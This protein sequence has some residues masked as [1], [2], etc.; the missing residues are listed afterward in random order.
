MTEMGALKERLKGCEILFLDFDGVLTDNRVMVSETGVESVVCDRSD[1]L[2]IRLLREC[3][4]IRVVIV[5]SEENGVVSARARKLKVDCIQNLADKL[6]VV[7]EEL[8]RS[9]VPASRAC[10]VGNDLNDIACLDYVGIAVG[11]PNA[12]A[13]VLSHVDYVTSR[14]G[15]RGA[16]R[17][18]C[19]LLLRAKKVAFEGTA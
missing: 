16:V 1:G 17:E 15:G 2:G 14:P 7:R 9:G 19:D 4:G 8:E 13:E 5:S 6:S 3:A 10:Y 18:L 12:A 11:V